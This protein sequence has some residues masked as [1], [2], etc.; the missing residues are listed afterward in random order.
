MRILASLLLLMSATGPWVEMD[1]ALEPWQAINDGVM[2]G[3]SRGR[4]VAADQGLRFEAR[5]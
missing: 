2:G 3:V 1:M 4:M 5:D